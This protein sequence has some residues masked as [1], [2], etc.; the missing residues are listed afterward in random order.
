MIRDLEKEKEESVKMETIVKKQTEFEVN[1][2]KLITILIKNSFVEK[3]QKVAKIKNDAKELIANANADQ[4]RIV[5]EAEVNWYRSIEDKHSKGLQ[6]IFNELGFS[7]TKHKASF[8][9]LQSLRDNEKVK[10][11]IDFNTLVQQTN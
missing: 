7:A 10:Y 3:K 6:K 2:K 1:F 4:D 11:S 9:Y 5:N 8:N